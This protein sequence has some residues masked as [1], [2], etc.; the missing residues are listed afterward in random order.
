M[1]KGNQGLLWI[2]CFVI[3]DWILWDIFVL[4]GSVLLWILVLFFDWI[5]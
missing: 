2:S 5:F 3:G 4:G 1:R